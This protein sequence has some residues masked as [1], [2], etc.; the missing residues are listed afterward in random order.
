MINDPLSEK[1]ATLEGPVERQISERRRWLNSTSTIAAEQAA[2]AWTRKEERLSRENDARRAFQLA[3]EMHASGLATERDVKEAEL[4]LKREREQT[5]KLDSEVAEI[6]Q[7]TSASKAPVESTN[8]LLAGLQWPTRFAS[9]AHFDSRDRRNRTM[10]VGRAP[11]VELVQPDLPD[12]DP[13]DIMTEAR[14]NVVRLNSEMADVDQAP[15]RLE[16]VERRLPVLIAD[17][18]A[19]GAPELLGVGEVGQRLAVGGPKMT[20]HAEPDRSSGA[21]GLI[22]KADDALAML[23]WVAPDKVLEKMRADLHEAYA[24]IDLQLD[25]HERHRRRRE[26]KAAILAAERVECAAIWAMI[27]GGDDTVRFR[28]DTDP[29]AILGIAV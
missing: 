20:I 2:T 11:D 14:A 27:E 12:T 19:R 8:R 21:R 18:A 22:P 23:A 1:V 16:S 26:I 25:P 15:D 17:L 13:R 5:A 10:E 7:W 24:T 29:R 6:H 28:P 3:N 4:A 9:L